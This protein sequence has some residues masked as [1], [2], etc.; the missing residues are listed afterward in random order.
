M[1]KN[2][3]EAR[4][5]T[6]VC[7]SSRTQLEYITLGGAT[8]ILSCDIGS[9]RIA[10]QSGEVVFNLSDK[11]VIPRTCNSFVNCRLNTD[12]SMVESVGITLDL[13]TTVG[14]EGVGSSGRFYQTLSPR[15][16]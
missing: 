7:S 15:L 14:H 10:S 13:V 8:V 12:T 4:A 1:K 16:W 3:L 9:T 5:E 6:I 2:I 11:D